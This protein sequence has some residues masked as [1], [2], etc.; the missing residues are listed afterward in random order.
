MGRRSGILHEG[1]VALVRTHQR[2]HP[3]PVYIERRQAKTLAFRDIHSGIDVNKVGRRAVS[4]VAGQRTHLMGPGGPLLCEILE[5][6][7]A[8]SL[9]VVAD[10][11]CRHIVA[12]VAEE[13][14]KMVFQPVAAPAGELVEHGRRPVSAVDLVGIVEEVIRGPDSALRECL[15]ES[16]QIIGDGSAAEM[17]DNQPFSSRG[18]AFHHLAGLADG[19]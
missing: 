18:G 19:N 7:V 14:G 11:T 9:A 10:Y 1:A 12:L 17:V 13:L 15:R 16:V 4:L 3:Q 5:Q 2:I 8:H 6:Q